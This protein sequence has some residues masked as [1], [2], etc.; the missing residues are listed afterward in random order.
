ME[1]TDQLTSSKILE[2]LCQIS[3]RL[4]D[5]DRRLQTSW[6]PLP[7][8]HRETA[9]LSESRIQARDYNSFRIKICLDGDGRAYLQEIIFQPGPLLHLIQ[10]LSGVCPRHP[11]TVDEVTYMFPF[12][13]IM[14]QWEILRIV[15]GH[16]S[17]Y[18]SGFLNRLCPK[19]EHEG[20]E[21]DVGE[22]LDCIKGSANCGPSIRDRCAELDNGRVS[23][24]HLPH[25]FARG[26]LI[27]SNS[28]EDGCQV[29]E[30]VSSEINSASALGDV[31]EVLYWY[32]RWSRRALIKY[33]GRF[34]VQRYTGTR[35]LKDLPF[36]PIATY[37]NPGET[38]E[39][40]YV[41][42][43]S[44]S[45]ALSFLR[46]LPPH[47]KEPYPR[48]SYVQNILGQSVRHS[49]RVFSP[50]SLILPQHW[51]FPSLNNC[52]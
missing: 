51:I 2:V 45:E 23:F 8:R 39:G 17:P 9:S 28:D 34:E 14:G 6:P 11:A 49:A 36:S 29:V 25:I 24:M 20:L 12:T 13:E 18:A 3:A 48:F 50:F 7:A 47:E 46:S 32:F 4:E 40:Y 44:S 21:R 41:S 31:C 19:G 43:E 22:L 30:V 1:N 42:L 26:A 38:L 33:N 37:S 52:W 15:R 5:I 10:T 27:S 35:R 16:A